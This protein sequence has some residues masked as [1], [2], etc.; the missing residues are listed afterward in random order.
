AF[1]SDGQLVTLDQ[2]GQVR[3]WNLDSQDEDK[4]SRRDLLIGPN[5]Q[6]RVL[7]PD[8]RLVALAEGNKVHV[9]DTSTG[10][11]N[12]QIDSANARD[13][14]LIFTPDGGRLVIVD[15]KIRWCAAA[16]GQ[17]VGSLNQEFNRGSSLALS[18]D[19]LT[20]AVVGHGPLG[21]QFSIFRLDAA[22]RKV[23]LQAKDAWPATNLVTLGAAGFSPDGRLIAVG[24]KLYGPVCVF[25]TVTGR[26][27]AQNGSAHASD[28]SAL[29]FSGDGAKLVTADVEGTIK[30]WEDARKLTSKSAA[31]MTLKGHEAVITHVGFS[32]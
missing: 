6:F 28:V 15:D 30:I 32:S 29:T 4:A 13:R 26:P 12:F 17:V 27:I 8:G 22:T 16:S 23:T 10:K 21:N 20:L 11:E 25:D 1:T 14:R 18:A 2:N 3:R 31:S 24:A 7:S 19:G 9:F 5:A